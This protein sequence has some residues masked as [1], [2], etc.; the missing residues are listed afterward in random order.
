[1]QNIISKREE[2]LLYPS[3]DGDVSLGNIELR[4]CKNSLIYRHI[5]PKISKKDSYESLSLEQL[6]K[7]ANVGKEKCEYINTKT[8]EKDLINW[9]KEEEKRTKIPHG[10]E[11]E[12]F[13]DEL[14]PSIQ[15]DSDEDEPYYVDDEY[16]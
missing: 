16:C 6:K 5:I 12:V 1:M 4:P 8:Y 2:N 15:N 11:D 10:D 14:I 7:I 3:T 9:I 13:Y